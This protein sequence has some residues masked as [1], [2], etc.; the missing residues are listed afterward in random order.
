MAGTTGKRWRVSWLAVDCRRPTLWTGRLRKTDTYEAL[1]ER[2]RFLTPAGYP[3]ADGSPHAVAVP[4]SSRQLQEAQAWR[5]SR[6]WRYSPWV[7]WN[8]GVAADTGW[9]CD[10]GRRRLDCVRRDGLP[11]EHAGEVRI[12]LGSGFESLPRTIP[13]STKPRIGG[14][15]PFPPAPA[16]RFFSSAC[17]VQAESHDGKAPSPVDRCPGG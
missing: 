3:R 1:G 14:P 17:H 10:R 2:E 6:L 7:S 11:A 9:D 5:E 16:P 8:R 4:Y 12:G 15:V 13:P